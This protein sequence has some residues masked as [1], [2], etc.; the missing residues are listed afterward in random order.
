MQSSTSVLGFNLIHPNVGSGSLSALKLDKDVESQRIVHVN[1]R[2]LRSCIGRLRNLFAKDN[3][4]S[5]ETSRQHT[6][7][8]LPCNQC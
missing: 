4:Y 3:Q 7:P 1:G 2:K 8:N 6:F 5:N